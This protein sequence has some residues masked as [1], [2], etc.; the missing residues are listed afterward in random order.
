[1]AQGGCHIHQTPT[2]YMPLDGIHK[3][4]NIVCVC[5]WSTAESFVLVALKF[6]T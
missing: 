1:M 3:K 6:G 5:V 2:L 4:A